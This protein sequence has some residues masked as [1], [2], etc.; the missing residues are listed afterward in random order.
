[1]SGV[2][3]NEVDPFAAAWLIALIRDGLIP[4][5]AVDTRSIVDVRP[6]DLKGFRQCHFFAGI[7]GWAHALVL[8]GWPDERPIWSGSAPCQPFSVA[9][10]GMGLADERHLWP[11]FFGLIQE[12]RPPVVVGEQVA[13]AAGYDWFD[14]V[15]SDLEGEGYAARAVDIPACAVDAPHIRQRLY[16]CAVEHAPRI[17]RAE[18]GPKHEFWGRRGAAAGAGGAS[19]LGNTDQPGLEGRFSAAERAGEQPAWPSGMANAN[20]SCASEEREQR[21]GEFLRAGQDPRARNGGFWADADWITGADGKARRVKPGVRLLAH[22]LSNRVG[23][24]RGYGNA[25]VPP[26]AAE[27]IRALMDAAPRG[28]ARREAGRQTR[29]CLGE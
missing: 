18:G 9:G 28:N 8:A 27:V 1:M 22:G 10:K 4:D 19:N 12:C 5:G 21:G 26:L 2:Y 23:R 14:G 25:I 7:A 17:G 20:Q 3:Y 6:G 16:W 15:S 29:V 24:L 13:G 11:V